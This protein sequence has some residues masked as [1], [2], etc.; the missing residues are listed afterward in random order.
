MSDKILLQK[1][2]SICTQSKAAMIQMQYINDPFISMFESNN[3]RRSPL[4]NRGYYIRTYI[5]RSIIDDF[6]L[7]CN[8]KCQIIVLGAGYDTLFMRVLENYP[9]C[10]IIEVDLPNVVNTKIDLLIN[11][12]YFQRKYGKNYRIINKNKPGTL[13]ECSNYSLLS[14]DIT[15]DNDIS[16]VFSLLKSNSIHTL[17]LS[18]VVFCYLK[19]E[20]TDNFLQK[21]YHILEKPVFVSYDQI[22][23]DNGFSVQMLEHFKNSG[24]PLLSLKALKST[25]KHYERLS[26]IGFLNINIFTLKMFH[27]SMDPLEKLRIKALE[28]F[29]EYEM[30]D[31]L[32]MSY[33]ITIAEKSQ[34]LNLYKSLDYVDI[35]YEP[36]PTDLSFITLDSFSVYNHSSFIYEKNGIK[37]VVCCVSNRNKNLCSKLLTY[38]ELGLEISLITNFPEVYYN[39]IIL[40]KSNKVF[41]FFGRKSPSKLV[42]P[43]CFRVESCKD[44]NNPQEM[45]LF[46]QQ[47]AFKN[48]S[49]HSHS[50][51]PEL[52]W[53]QSCCKLFHP[54]NNKEFVVL[55]AGRTLDKCLNDFWLFDLEELVWSRLD[56]D[57]KMVGRHSHSLCLNEFS[58]DVFVLGGL[59]EDDRA[60][61]DSFM[62]SINVDSLKISIKT[63]NFTPELPKIYGH[64]C[65][66]LKDN[67]FIIFGGISPKAEQLNHF[68]LVDVRT[69]IL[70]S[71]QIQSFGLDSIFVGFS[72]HILRNQSINQKNNE[73]EIKESRHLVIVGGGGVCFTFGLQTN[74][75]PFLID[76]NRI[77]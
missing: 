39:S 40:S 61:S 22:I 11:N 72:S 62:V 74:K 42:D 5:L 37:R 3:I 57:W 46:D 64:D 18:E 58:G 25:D 2:N 1:T 38:H 34:T 20:Q 65:H 24:A 23:I 73:S 32:C 10:D 69:N 50:N 55:H 8:Y 59:S 49:N 36:I 56:S 67:Q 63:M 77:K 9:H 53:R 7:K 31:L 66:W 52:R 16:H 70:L 43:F 76:L 45:E 27:D 26:K 17:I 19:K 4:V 48:S 60:L 47:S 33:A 68:Y 15:V 12:E 6:L 44:P 28:I 14:R 35:S 54:L 29:D 30:W 75:N 13:F 51:L 41:S 21:A 71:Y